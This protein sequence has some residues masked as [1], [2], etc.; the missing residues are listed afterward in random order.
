MK[1]PHR[2]R[3]LWLFTA[4]AL[5]A[6][7]AFAGCK[8]D[9]KTGGKTPGAGETPLAADQTLRVRIAGEPQALDPQVTGFDVDISIVK[10]LFRGLFYY[11]GPDMNVVPSVAAKIPTQGD[12]ISDDGLTYTIELRDDV[13]WSDGTPLTAN[14]FVYALRRLFDPEAGATGYYYS[15]Y[16]A[17]VG[18]EAAAAGTGTLEDIGVTAVND[19]TLEIKL[20]RPQPTLLTLLAMWPAYPVRQDI[21]E[22]KGDAWFEAGN[23]IGNGPMVLSEWVHQDHVTMTA[24]PN[25][26]GDDK[27]TIQTLVFR[28][29]PDEPKALIAYENNEIDL[30]PIPLPDTATF[31]GNA[32]QLKYEELTV[33]AWEFNNEREPFDNPEVRKAFS[34]ATDR[35][36]YISAVRGGVGHPTTSWLPPGIPG[37]LETRCSEWAFDKDKAQQ[38]LTDAGFPNGEGLPEVTLTFA[39]SQANRLSFDFLQQQIEQNL[40][41]RIEVEV[42]ESATYEDHYLASDFQ[43][44]LGGWGADYADP[45]NWLPQLFGTDASSNQY[46]YSNTDFDA[47]MDQAATELDND[48]RIKLY[49]DAEAILI[50]EDVGVAPLFNRTRNWLLKPYV[51]GFTT[52]GLDGNVP[53]DFFYNRVSILEH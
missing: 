5:I 37:Y 25:Y 6:V 47:L 34:L 3:W 11:D 32:E 29:I 36:T 21:I 31:E 50:D 49:Q 46:K 19:T 18:A 4:I 1:L 38:V 13:T 24:D 53:G 14:D 41:F 9:K 7:L 45:E 27:P 40:G 26:W 20:T 35:D 16:T 52:T 8:D 10:Q 2:L 17:I 22:A 30:A 39:D 12:G 33:F 28:M 23:L 48:K 51:D 42:L 15:F 43:V 44:V